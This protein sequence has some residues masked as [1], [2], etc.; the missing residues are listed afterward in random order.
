MMKI[1]R[2]ICVLLILTMTAAMLTSAAASDTKLR[3]DDRGES[4]RQL[5]QMLKQLGYSI[6]A[7][8]VFG[9]GTEDAV[10]QFQAA[11]G[12]EVDGVAGS[13]TLSRL[14]SM[15]SGST[16]SQSS[17]NTATGLF[18]G[19]YEKM[20]RGETSSRVRILQKALNDLGYNVGKVDAV[21]GAGTESAV[22]WFQQVQGLDADGKAGEKTLMRIESFF[23][24]NGTVRSDYT[25]PAATY[26]PLPTATPA[27]TN[28][29]TTGS[30]TGASTIPTRTLR[31]GDNG[32]DVRN[33]QVRLQALGYYAGSLDGRYGSGTE[34]AVKQFQLR[35]GLKADGK[36]G[37]ATNA[38]LFGQNAIAA[39]ATAAPATSVITPAP[40]TGNA[41]LF[42]GN[43][44]KLV[45]GDV[46]SRVRTLQTALN[47][48]GYNVGK[49]DAV[50][51]AATESAVRLFQQIHGLSVDGKAGEKTLRK[52]ESLF[53]ADGTVKS[54][55]NAPATVTPPAET[56][57]PTTTPAPA[58]TTAPQY[59]IPTR[60]LSAGTSGSDVISV[61]SR[62]RE[63]GYYNGALDGVYGT[64]TVTAVTAFQKANGLNADGKAGV[65]TY[66]ILF[67]DKAVGAGSTLPEATSTPM[68]YTTLQKGASG[69]AVTQLQKAL[70][71]LGYTVNTNGTYNNETV[72]AVKKF[73]S[74]N[75]LNVDGVA[76]P[77]TLAKLYSGT[78]VGPSAAS[79]GPGTTTA[80]V[81]SN[82]PS[83]SDIKLLHWYNDIKP[84][85][86]GQ[87]VVQIYDPASGLTWN[88][89]I[90]S[91]GQ[92]ADGEPPTLQDTQIMYK[93]FGN[94]FTWNEKPVFVK[95]P[96]GVW[97]IASMH[98]R[99]HESDMV[100]AS[101]N[102]FEIPGVSDGHLC[103]HFPRDMEETKKNAP[104]NGVRHQNDIRKKW[105]Q[106]TGQDIPW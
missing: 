40:A 19:N 12:L 20:Y 45:R 60:T 17:S 89:K 74:S 8:G 51:G 41:N 56:A 27:P 38:A 33:V 70:L 99:P 71:S 49:V 22:R 105:K 87:P 73:Q 67:S 30:I 21:Y 58:T 97:C 39:S 1:K 82:P 100:K 35:N 57:V 69:E 6:S 18:G 84:N 101:V 85:L 5:Q 47:K 83:N 36:A 59:T 9:S 79:D 42:S 63:L 4:V 78:A 91:K 62:L 88:I 93:A 66:A 98:D 37:A 75:G 23:N 95:L 52:I 11:Q 48:L 7:D 29:G 2:M 3:Y 96:S 86:S 104:S 13:A 61:Q 103:I 50:Y 54:D 55:Y 81:M 14:R 102:G 25:P 77:N 90:F 68:I 53:N 72:D 28:A 15:T 26:A 76:G 44:T 10:K 80:G 106:M 31:P 16:S 65:L 46:S 24:A 32:E 64:G 43:Y 94:Q 92:H 34:D